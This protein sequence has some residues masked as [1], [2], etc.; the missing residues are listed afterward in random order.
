MHSVTIIN[1]RSYAS[2]DLLLANDNLLFTWEKSGEEK[3]QKSR[4]LTVHKLC[5]R[6]KNTRTMRHN[7]PKDGKVP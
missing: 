6:W 4:I 1:S 5:S 3:K 2:C 7:E